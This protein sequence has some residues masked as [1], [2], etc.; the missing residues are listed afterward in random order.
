M[1]GDDARMYGIPFA[2]RMTII[3]LKSGGL[4]I[5]SPVLPNAERLAAVNELGPV[6]HLI[7]PNKIH[8]LGIDPWKARYPEAKVWVSPQFNQRHPRIKADAILDNDPPPVWRGEIDQC[9]FDG[10]LFL[11]EVLFV[12]QPS[13]TLIVT[14]LIQKHDPAAQ[15]WFSRHLKKFAGVLGKDGGTALDLRATFRDRSAARRSLERILHWDF[16]NLIISHGLCVHGG[17]RPVVEKAFSWL[18]GS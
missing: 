14:D 17:A 1:A 2:T 8:S 6:K 3:R 4:W 18:G 5:H 9:I 10:S 12:H 16:D 13:R 7:A 11:D 15:S